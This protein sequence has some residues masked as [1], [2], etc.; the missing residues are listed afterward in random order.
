M[1]GS[2]GRRDGWHGVRS[3][4]ADGCLRERSIASIYCRLVTK[5][6]SY[7]PK[8]NDT[9]CH[10]VC[11]FHSTYGPIFKNFCFHQINNDNS[12]NINA[13]TCEATM[14]CVLDPQTFG[15]PQEWQG[16]RRHGPH[17]AHQ[18]PSRIAEA[19][20]SMHKYLPRQEQ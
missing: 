15:N 4:R 19:G 18:C 3:T 14:I 12:A 13:K 16:G 9:S 8:L 6:F 1:K 17:R 2:E 5:R 10:S 7:I 20:C 11:C